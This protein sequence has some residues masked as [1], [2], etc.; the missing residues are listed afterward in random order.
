MGHTPIIDKFA[1]EGVLFTRAFASAPVCSAS[2]S[3]LITGVMQTT[4]G[5]HQHRSSQTTDGQIVPEDTRIYLPK[6]IITLPELMKDTGYFTFNSRKDD[7][8]FH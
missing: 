1:S 5:T 7:Y 3:A 8:N 2:R 6:G 4:N